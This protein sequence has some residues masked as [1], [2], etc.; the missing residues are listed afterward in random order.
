MFQRRK[1]GSSLEKRSQSRV[2]RAPQQHECYCLRMLFHVVKSPTSFKNLCAVNSVM[3]PFLQ[4]ACKTF[5]LLTNDSHQDK[6]LIE[7]VLASSASN[8]EFLFS[9]ILALSDLLFLSMKHRDS[10][11]GHTLHRIWTKHSLP[12]LKFNDMIFISAPTEIDK[13]VQSILG[14]SERTLSLLL[15][16]SAHD[17]VTNKRYLQLD[18]P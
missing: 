3:R 7:A 18:Q 12:D 14:K 9:A 16:N 6:T 13:I 8:V 1:Q 17:L 2:R 15:S 5:D 11:P 10:A 4:P